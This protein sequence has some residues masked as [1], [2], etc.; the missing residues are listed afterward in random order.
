MSSFGK[1]IQRKK[2]KEFKKELTK[3]VGLFNQLP[4]HCLTCR[5]DF[6]KKNK[7]MVMSWSVVV[8]NDQN[9][10]RL[11]CPQ[12]W[13]KAKELIKE[14]EDGLPSSKNNV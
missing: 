4:D 9:K 11:Y 6:D 13:N 2:E 1:K 10:V 5:K 12:C 8:R 7:D 3:K 14:I